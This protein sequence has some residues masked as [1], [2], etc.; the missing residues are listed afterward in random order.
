MPRPPKLVWLAGPSSKIPGVGQ[1]DLGSYEPAF[2]GSRFDGGKNYRL[3]GTPSPTAKQ[4]WS[5]TLSVV[6]T[7]S[8]IVT[9]ERIA[10]RSSRMDLINNPDHSVAIDI[11][12][13]APKGFE[14]NWIPTVPGRGDGVQRA[15]PP[16]GLQPL[17]RG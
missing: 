7:G 16:G 15:D 10:D 4:F 3:H 12:P 8:L 5:V 9:K 6:D 14:R 11:G 13:K 1:A 17:V 2:D